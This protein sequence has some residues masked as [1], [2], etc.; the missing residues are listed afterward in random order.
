MIKCFVIAYILTGGLDNSSHVAHDDF[1][2]PTKTECNEAV[3][4]SGKEHLFCVEK[5]NG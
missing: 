4:A 2:F 1:C 5:K 3:K